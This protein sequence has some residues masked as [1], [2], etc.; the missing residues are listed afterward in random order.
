MMVTC[1]A[2]VRVQV[3]VLSTRPSIPPDMPEDYELLSKR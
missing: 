1:A 3:V 2:A